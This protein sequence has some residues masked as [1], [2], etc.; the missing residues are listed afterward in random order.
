MH[1]FFGSWLF[2]LWELGI[3]IRVLFLAFLQIHTE[4]NEHWT[5]QKRQLLDN[6]KHTPPTT[7]HLLKL[8]NAKEDKTNHLFKKKGCMQVGQ[9]KFNI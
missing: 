6:S 3:G 2:F 5:W 1:T 7:N 4:I 9:K 8:W